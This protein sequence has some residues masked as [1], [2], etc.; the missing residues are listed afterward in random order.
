MT[1]EPSHT[2]E[3]SWTSAMTVLLQLNDLQHAVAAE[4]HVSFAMI[5]AM[6]RRPMRRGKMHVGSYKPRPK[7]LPALRSNRCAR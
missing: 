1:Q 7:F 2:I 3:P 4:W 5:Y 6:D